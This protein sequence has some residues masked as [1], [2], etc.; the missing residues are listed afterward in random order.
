MRNYSFTLEQINSIKHCIGFDK[1]KVTGV[2]HRKMNACR[3]YYITGDNE[4]S[5]DD[6]VEQGLMIKRD[7]QLGSGD[8]PQI[9][10]VTEKGF[11]FLS[12][13]TEIE[14]TKME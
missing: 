13:L 5:L 2:K 6:L 4:D 11:K 14:I 9:Y 12:D 10:Y 1:S 7:Y 3:N 8:N